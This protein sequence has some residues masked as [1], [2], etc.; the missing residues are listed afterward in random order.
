MLSKYKWLAAATSKIRFPP[1]R[2]A[3]QQELAGHIE[4]LTD[5]YASK[6]LDAEAA[7]AAALEAMGDPEAIAPELGRIHRPWP[8]YLWWLSRG[9]VIAAAVYCLLLFA[10]Q[11]YR[12]PNGML[13]YRLLGWEYYDC[14][15]WEF[16]INA[17]EGEQHV[18]IPDGRVTTGGYTIRADRAAMRRTAAGYWELLVY[19][20]IAPNWRNEE[21]DW[22]AD[23][24]AEIR[25][26][27]GNVYGPYAPASDRFYY[28]G[29]SMAA[30]GLGQ[31]AAL[32]LCGV[33]EKMEWIEA[34]IGFGR[35]ERIMHID[36]KEETT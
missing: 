17:A 10:Q 6:G 31:K 24:I 23:T 7:E 20:R 33:P 32:E 14:L 21:L 3:V 36:L 5:H 2:K 34:R 35:L 25:D 27:A 12:D 19:F 26:S 28:C 1:D 11:I 9:L 15:T 18:L 29:A 4:D 8:G 30:W 22:S 16:G 13:P